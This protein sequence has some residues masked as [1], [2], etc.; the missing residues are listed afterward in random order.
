MKAVGRIDFKPSSSSKICGNHFHH[1]DYFVNVHGTKTLKKGA[2]PSIF[3]FSG[4]LPEGEKNES[5]PVQY[6]TEGTLIFSSLN[7][8]F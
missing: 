2:I 1:H 3:N 8:L 5:L 7:T 6:E 4:H